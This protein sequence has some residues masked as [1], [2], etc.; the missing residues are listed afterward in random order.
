MEN[1]KL[2]IRDGGWW[3]SEVN[4]LEEV[5]K[6]FSIPDKVI[7]H[8]ATL[9]DGEQTPGVVFKKEEKLILAKALDSVG[10]DR[11]EAGM[12][13]VAPEDMQALLFCIIDCIHTSFYDFFYTPVELVLQPWKSDGNF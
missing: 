7:I 8:D 12:P 6:T 3:T 11:I 1:E 2:W 13:A 5:R 9:R 10:V 4:F